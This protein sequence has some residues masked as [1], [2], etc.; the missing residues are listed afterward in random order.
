MG[1][2]GEVMLTGVNC[3]PFQNGLYQLTYQFRWHPGNTQIQSPYMVG[4]TYDKAQN[5]D[6][7]LRLQNNTIF[8]NQPHWRADF[9]SV[10]QISTEEW[11]AVGIW[12]SLCSAQAYST[13]ER[14]WFAR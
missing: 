6:N 12:G 7:S 2:D 1:D 10:L 13:R 8:W 3:N 14:R 9:Q 5:P 4:A 11:D